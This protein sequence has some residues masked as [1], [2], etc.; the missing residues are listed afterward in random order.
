[1]LEYCCVCCINVTPN[2]A[3]QIGLIVLLCGN[4]DQRKDGVGWEWRWGDGGWRPV[5]I[6][7]NLSGL[8]SSS[9]HR[10][11][12]NPWNFPRDQRVFVIHELLDHLWVY[13]NKMTQDEPLDS[14]R[15]GTDWTC[16]IS[17]TS[18]PPGRGWGREIEFS[19]VASDL[20]KL[21]Y[22]MTSFPGGSMV[23][24]PPASTE[25]AGSIPGLGRSPRGGNGNPFHYSCLGN[26]MDRGAWRATVHGFVKESGHDLATKQQS[27]KCN[28]TPVKTET[29]SSEE[30]P[31][32]WAHLCTRRLVSPDSRGRGLK[33]LCLGTSQTPPY[34]FLFIWLLIYNKTAIISIMLSRVLWVILVKRWTEGITGT[35]DFIASWSEEQVAWGLPQV[36]LLS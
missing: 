17:L 11:S 1:M 23:K 31:G 2:V 24:N 27:N 5:F 15:L 32:C 22:V 20:I 26:A 14:L 21:A 16:D 30:R 9:W 29:L 33:A 4:Y 25:D 3:T 34:V 13:A 28:D 18:Q 7:K 35:L 8:C 6:R 36:W 12:K 10:A 19:P